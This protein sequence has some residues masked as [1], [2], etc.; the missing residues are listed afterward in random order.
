VHEWLWPW[1]WREDDTGPEP[2]PRLHCGVERGWDGPFHVLL[3]LLLFVLFL[4][5]LLLLLFLL[6]F[7]LCHGLS[8][9]PQVYGAGLIRQPQSTAFQ[10]LLLP[11]ANELLGA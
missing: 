2:R 7:L 1:P 5:L 10:R 4:F 6:L 3:L 8:R 11:L 9:C